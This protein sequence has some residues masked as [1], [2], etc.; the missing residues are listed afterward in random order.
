MQC[1][2]FGGHSCD[3]NGLKYDIIALKT[4][5]LIQVAKCVRVFLFC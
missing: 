5:K 3:Q 2:L 4:V 1:A